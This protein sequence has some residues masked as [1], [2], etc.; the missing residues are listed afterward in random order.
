V[1]SYARR[2][3]VGGRIKERSLPLAQLGRVVMDALSPYVNSKDTDGVARAVFGQLLLFTYPPWLIEYRRIQSWRYA[4]GVALGMR[5]RNI[6][7]D[8]PINWMTKAYI[9]AVYTIVT[10]CGLI[11]PIRLFQYLKPRLHAFAKRS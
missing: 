6:T 4:A 11:F 2:E 5:P 10:I 3:R 7:R 1:D 9:T 8:L